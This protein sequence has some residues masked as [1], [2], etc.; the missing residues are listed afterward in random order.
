MSELPEELL[1]PHP[2]RLSPDHPAYASIMA[3]HA[4]AMARDADGY[5][6]PVSG[7]WVFTAAFLHERGFCCERGCRH[8]PWVAR[9]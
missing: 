4:A 8:C 5:V 6:D 2:E 7:Y 1:D 3:E 9:G